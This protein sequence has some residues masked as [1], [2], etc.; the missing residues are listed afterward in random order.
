MSAFPP[1]EDT[2]N[3]T[4]F[5]LMM[6]WLGCHLSNRQMKDLHFSARI[7]KGVREVGNVP[8]LIEEQEALT[9]FIQI[10][11]QLID[12]DQPDSF[13]YDVRSAMSRLDHWLA[14]TWRRLLRRHK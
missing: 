5:D 8:M 12:F 9:R 7:T 14:I 1:P 4:H 3:T 13:I 11:E 2:L 6:S 10:G